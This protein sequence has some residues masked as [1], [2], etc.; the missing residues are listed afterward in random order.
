M[1]YVHENKT[2]FSAFVLQIFLF[3]QLI[4]Q[5]CM[6]K[7][8][9]LC[10]SLGTASPSIRQFTHTHGRQKASLSDSHVPFADCR[11]PL[12]SLH[13]QASEDHTAMTR[14]Q[15]RPSCPAA[16]VV[17]FHSCG[18]LKPSKIEKEKARE[19]RKRL[20]KTSQWQDITACCGCCQTFNYIDLVAFHISIRSFF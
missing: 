1:K 6:W 14:P 12:G 2:H 15:V 16:S 7:H 18:S 8:P 9:Q 11:I 17:W 20:R 3:P 4:K 10:V 13:L 19:R 5:Q